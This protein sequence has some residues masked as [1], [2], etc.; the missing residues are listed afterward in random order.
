MPF[1]EQTILIREPLKTVMNALNDVESIPNWATVPGAIENVQGRGVGMT[2][3]WR[4]HINTLNFSGKSEVIEQTETTLITK[5]TGDIDSIWSIHLTPIGPNSTNLHVLVE[6]SPPNTFV[7]ILADMVLQQISDP[8]VARENI[9]RFKNWVEEKV[10]EE[11]VI[12]D[13]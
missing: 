5:T 2:Y 9:T 8:E 11:G 13:L 4:Y 10:I 6:Y 1:V 7:E 12:A 3:H